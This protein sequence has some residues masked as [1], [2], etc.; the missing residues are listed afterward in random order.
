MMLLLSSKMTE[1]DGLV[2][3][4]SHNGEKY[5]PRISNIIVG[6]APEFANLNLL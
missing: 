5:F 3:P 6:E 4:L 2:N 1:L